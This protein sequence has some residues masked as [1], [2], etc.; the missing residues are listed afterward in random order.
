MGGDGFVG[1]V[2]G[3]GCVDVPKA[4]QRLQVEVPKGWDDERG[5]NHVVA[6][7]ILHLLAR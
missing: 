5:D 6:A 1:C 4:R 7:N 2:F 3:R